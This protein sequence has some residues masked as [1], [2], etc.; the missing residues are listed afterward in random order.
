MSSTEL[1]KS[2][3]AYGLTDKEI[4]V[5]LAVLS[6]D[7]ATVREISLA[8][9]IKRTSVYLVADKLVAKGI[10]GS[11]KAKYGTHYVASQPQSL[12]TRLDDIKAEVSTIIPQLEAIKKRDLHEPRVN[13]YRGKQGYLTVLNASL[14][15][16]SHEV[17]YIGSAE[18]LNG[19]VSEQYVI[20]KYI[21]I[22]LKRKITFKQIVFADPFSQNLKKNDFAELRQTK[23][24]PRN[25]AFESN[26][27][28]FHDSVA[29]FSSKRELACVLIGSQDIAK[30]EMEKYK[31]LWE[32]LS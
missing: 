1:K 30:M 23:F 19:I 27:L 7:S 15:G 3:R 24:L 14:E 5:Y 10:L 29:Y 17:L 12:L 11:Y 28:I 6:L 32:K 9:K 31:L 22:R 21:P 26:M 13:F 18:A 4:A 2:L 16:Y 20:E 25:Y 8:T